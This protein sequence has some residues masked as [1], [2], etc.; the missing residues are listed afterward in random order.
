ML[1]VLLL[2][3]ETGEFI[4]SPHIKVD[5]KALQEDETITATKWDQKF[6]DKE[7]RKNWQHPWQLKLC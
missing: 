4:Y 5:E 7:T 3:Q 6:V 2:F 1:T